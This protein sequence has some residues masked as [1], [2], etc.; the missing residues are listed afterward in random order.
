MSKK[1][2]EADRVFF[3]AQRKRLLAMRAELLGSDAAR[4]ASE[5]APRSDEAKEME[6]DA[7]E[8]ART[9][10]DEAVTAVEARRLNAIDRALAKIEEGTYGFSDESGDPI[11]RKRLEAIPEAVLTIAEE[12]AREKRAGR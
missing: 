4:T 8:M 6:E 2:A 7:Q 11:P 10:V 9:E 1:G 5:R 3:E 12:E